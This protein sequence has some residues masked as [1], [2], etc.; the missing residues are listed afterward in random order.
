MMNCH[1][2]LYHDNTSNWA[3]MIHH[4]ESWWFRMMNDHDSAL[5]F[6][7]T[8]NDVSSW[9]M[10]V[11]IAITI[12]I[13]IIMNLDDASWWITMRHPKRIP[14]SSFCHGC[15]LVSLRESWFFEW[16]CIFPVFVKIKHSACSKYFEKQCPK[17]PTPRP[18]GAR[19]VGY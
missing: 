10:I 3:I 13:T 6:I 11:I 4:N 1:D 15:H 2:V 17:H 19:A 12:I 14:S 7:L 18:R 8:H 9:C 16:M 5:R